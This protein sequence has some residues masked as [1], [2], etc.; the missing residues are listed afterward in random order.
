MGIGFYF[1]VGGSDEII[2]V[3]YWLHNSMAIL[4]TIEVYILNGGIKWVNKL[5]IQ[6]T[7]IDLKKKTP[8]FTV[9]IEN[10]ILKCIWKLHFILAKRLRSDNIYM[11]IKR[12]IKT[13]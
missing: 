2:L 9:Q 5:Y 3:I 10:M 7:V 12:K 8:G 1:G 11:E 13:L 6:K 4:K